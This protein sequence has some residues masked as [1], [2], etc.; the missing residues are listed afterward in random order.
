MTTRITAHFY[1]VSSFHS[2]L[3][4]LL[5]KTQEKPILIE[6]SSSEKCCCHMIGLVPKTINSHSNTEFD[7]AILSSKGK[8]TI[9]ENEQ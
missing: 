6:K 2:F 5:A 1:Q 7:N 4:S 8:Y 3:Q 9:F